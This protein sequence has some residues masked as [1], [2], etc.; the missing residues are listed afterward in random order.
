MNQGNFNTGVNNAPPA[1][2]NPFET[3]TQ[4]SVQPEQAP[5]PNVATSKTPEQQPM[6][7][8][9]P[10]MPPNTEVAPATQTIEEQNPEIATDGNKIE[11]QWVHK[12]EKVV[13]QYEN[14]PH[15]E[16]IEVNKLKADYMAK[17]FNRHLGDRN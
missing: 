1:P 8:P 3:L 9:S 2:E 15:T 16:E 7:P 17:R 10:M 5:T 13:R 14:D 6:M 4:P 12:T 11:E